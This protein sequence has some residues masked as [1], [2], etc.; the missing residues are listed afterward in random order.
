MSESLKG[1][2]CLEGTINRAKVAEEVNMWRFQRQ[3][4]L[5]KLLW[6][7][8]ERTMADS[9]W[10]LDDFPRQ[11]TNSACRCPAHPFRPTGVHG[12]YCPFPKAFRFAPPATHTQLKHTFSTLCL[13]FTLMFRCIHHHLH[14]HT[15]AWLMY[16]SRANRPPL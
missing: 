11:R 14:T 12:Y 2:Y 3:W 4:K 13:V 15:L 7:K 8:F 16:V 1:S 6:V 5:E 10:M 9:L